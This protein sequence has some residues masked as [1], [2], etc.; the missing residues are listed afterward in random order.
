L[1]LIVLLGYKQSYNTPS[2]S[3]I[4]IILPRC[5]INRSLSLSLS[6]SFCVCLSLPLSL[7][8]SFSVYFPSPQLRLFSFSSASCLKLKVAALSLFLSLSIYLHLHTH[9]THT[10]THVLFS[11]RVLLWHDPL[12]HGS[13]VHKIGMQSNFSVNTNF[14]LSDL[15]QFS[16]GL[17]ALTAAFNISILLLL[18][19]AYL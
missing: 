1:L 15:Q 12:C 19:K 16:Q 17:P 4:S 10:H 5:R 2:M 7:F 8:L 9:T 13:V 6:L 11:S 18:V 3:N 14:K